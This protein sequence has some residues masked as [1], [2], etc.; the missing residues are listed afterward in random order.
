MMERLPLSTDQ[1][2]GLAALAAL[3]LLNLFVRAF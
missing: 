3:V 2:L 1:R